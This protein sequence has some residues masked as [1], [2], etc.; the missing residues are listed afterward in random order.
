MCGLLIQLCCRIVA[1]A[2]TLSD[3]AFVFVCLSPTALVAPTKLVV[4]SHGLYGAAI[5]M[6]VLKEE[7]QR[8]GGA[9]VRVHCAAAN[10]GR[11]RDGVAAGGRRLA[12]EVERIARSTP[13]METISL[14]GNSLGGLY[15]R[16]AAGELLDTASGRLAGLEPDVFVTIGCPHLGVRQFTYLPLPPPLRRLG[17]LVAGRTATDLLLGDAGCGE[18]GASTPLL[19]EMAREGGRYLESPN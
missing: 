9:D 7:L 13:S 11:T 8:L 1:R 12:A 4:L 16:Y 2:L 6:A 3:M 10:E 5:N 18:G 14:V 17:P 15:T 19:V